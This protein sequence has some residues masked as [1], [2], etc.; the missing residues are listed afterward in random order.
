MKKF[1]LAL[2]VLALAAGCAPAA[3]RGKTRRLK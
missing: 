3:P 1:I 2:T